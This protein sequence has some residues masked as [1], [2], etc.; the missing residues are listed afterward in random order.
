ME[1]QN[2]LAALGSLVEEVH[3]SPGEL[4]IMWL[5]REVDQVGE[6]LIRCPQHVRRYL[7]PRDWQANLQHP[8]QKQG[9]LSH[10]ISLSQG[11]LNMRR[12][13]GA[14]VRQVDGPG[15]QQLL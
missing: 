13:V 10:C 8:P 1:R 6:S 11:Y 3:S 9:Y 2:G 15:P 14:N 4:Q 5:E 7:L 12:N